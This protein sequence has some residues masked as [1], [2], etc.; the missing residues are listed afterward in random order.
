[1]RAHSHRHTGCNQPRRLFKEDD[2]MFKKLRVVVS[3]LA[4]GALFST[5]GCSA[6]LGDGVDMAEGE[7]G[8]ESAQEE[9]GEASC[10]TMICSAANSCTSVEINQCGPVRLGPVALPPYGS[11]ACPA[12][13]VAE[14]K[15]PPT[16]GGKILGISQWRGPSLTA[17]N[18]ASAKVEEALYAK[19]GAAAAP[20]LVGT[21][22]WKGVW[23]GNSCTLT[24]NAAKPFVNANA[25]LKA[26]RS[27]AR[28][29]LGATQV[30]VSTGFWNVCGP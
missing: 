6:E 10:G 7:A 15:T 29:T 20:T 14:D 4:L 24:S 21:I 28:A 26:V 2:G 9:L 8:L 17:A 13:A 18:C 23:G 11:P 12:Q 3:S 25:Q 1:L 27:T 30:P 22:T 16:S 5:V 19:T